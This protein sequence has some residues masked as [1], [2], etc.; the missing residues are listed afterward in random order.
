MDDCDCPPEVSTSTD[1]QT[2]LERLLLSNR[3]AD[4]KVTVAATSTQ[5]KCD[6]TVLVD[7]PNLS[8]PI[9][10]ECSD[11]MTP[12]QGAL[13]FYAHKAILAGKFDHFLGDK[14]LSSLRH[15]MVGPSY[16]N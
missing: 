7:I 1:L 10:C 14:K 9:A 11:C 4:V 8:C 13:E 3:L 6:G 15:H 2:D 16:I 12:T 5:Q